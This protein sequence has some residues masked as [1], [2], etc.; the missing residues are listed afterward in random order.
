[1]EI[2]EDKVRELVSEVTTTAE[3]LGDNVNQ[4]L[5]DYLPSKIASLAT[6]VDKVDITVPSDCT[7]WTSE[8]TEAVIASVNSIRNTFGSSVK[9]TVT[10]RS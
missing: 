3:L 4:V 2:T 8:V 5:T 6:D 10:V 1:M 7:H 9:C